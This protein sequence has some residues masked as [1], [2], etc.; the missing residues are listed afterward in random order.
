MVLFG[1]Q[2]VGRAKKN[3]DYDVGVLF[4]EPSDFRKH[5]LDLLPII[6]DTIRVPEERIDLANLGSDNILLR[7][8]ITRKGKL[9]SGDPADFAQYRGFAFR[10][11]LDATPLFAVEQTLIDRRQQYLKQAL[12]PV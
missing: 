8:Q 6:S 3:S 4:F 10:E 12:S 9:L 7:Y 11:Y 2:A 1:S 5:Y